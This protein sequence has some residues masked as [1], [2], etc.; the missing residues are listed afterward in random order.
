V[1]PVGVLTVSDRA[2]RGLYEDKGGPG[3]EVALARI[4]ATPWRP[5][6]RLVPDEAPLIEAALAALADEEACPLIVTTGG[7]GPRRAT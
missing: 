7:T 2:F 1:I 4:L 5:V 6:R 3:I